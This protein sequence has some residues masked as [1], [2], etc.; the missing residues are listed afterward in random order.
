MV[1]PC[2]GAREFFR[3]LTNELSSEIVVLLQI[4]PVNAGATGVDEDV[5]VGD[6]PEPVNITVNVSIGEA[7]N[8]PAA[9]HLESLTHDTPPK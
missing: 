1:V 6:D 2:R 4:Q 3:E 9:T 7:F 5:V 8:E